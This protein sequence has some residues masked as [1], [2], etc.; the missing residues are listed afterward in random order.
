MPSISDKLGFGPKREAFQADDG[1]LVK[2]TPPSFMQLPAQTVIL[3]SAQY[4]GYERWQ[5][6][7]MIQ[8]AM[9]TVPIHIRE[10]LMTGI[11]QSDWDEMWKEED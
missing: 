4:A 6:G 3:T 2:I 9:P 10:I 11:G 1:F 8:V 7:E 5:A